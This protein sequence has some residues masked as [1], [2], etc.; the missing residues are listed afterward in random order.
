MVE[1][2]KDSVILITTNDPR[3][4]RQQVMPAPRRIASLYKLLHI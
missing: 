3:G 2:M 1:R 4:L